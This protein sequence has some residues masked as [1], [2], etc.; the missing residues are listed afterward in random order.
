MTLQNFIQPGVYRNILSEFAVSSHS[1]KRRNHR[2]GSTS[3]DIL[4]DTISIWKRVGKCPKE[5]RRCVKR[6]K[7]GWKCDRKV[8]FPISTLSISSTWGHVVVDIHFSLFQKKKKEN[9]RKRKIAAL[10]AY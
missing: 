7:R 9:K 3:L 5:T 8:H 4:S 10:D 2:G 1:R 6:Y